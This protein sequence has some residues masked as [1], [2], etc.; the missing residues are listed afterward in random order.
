MRKPKVE[1]KYNLKPS[2]INKLVVNDRSKIKEPLFW[3]NDVINAWCISKSIGTDADRKYCTDNSV[4]IGI[5]DKPYYC[6]E[7]HCY[8]TCWGG[9]GR[10]NFNEFFNYREIETEKDLETQE[11][12]L[13]YINRLLDKGI[14]AIVKNV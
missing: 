12:L 1:N 7:V 11:I 2:D 10:Y 4:W 5:Y 3:R 8:C 13:Q 14:L 9:M 6:H